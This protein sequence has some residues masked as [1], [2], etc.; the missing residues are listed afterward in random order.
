ML[1]L[2]IELGYIACTALSRSR[3]LEIMKLT[4]KTAAF[5]IILAFVLSVFSLAGA[6]EKSAAVT[7]RTVGGNTILPIQDLRPG[8]KGVARTVFSGSAPEDFGIEIIGV[9]PSF[10]GPRQS[11]IIGKLSGANVDKTG[12]FAGMS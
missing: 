6:Q 9:L 1:L 7:L 10:N 12:V 8:M 2:S 5:L 11:L 3:A 4:K